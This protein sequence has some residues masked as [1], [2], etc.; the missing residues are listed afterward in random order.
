MAPT[1]IFAFNISADKEQNLV[2]QWHNLHPHHFHSHNCLHHH[3][4]NHHYSII[5]LYHPHLAI[6]RI[7]LLILKEA[8]ALVSLFRALPLPLASFAHFF[9]KPKCC[10]QIWLSRLFIIP[11][12][13]L[14]IQYCSA[15]LSVL[16]VA[17]FLVIYQ[18][19]LYICCGS[20][21]WGLWPRQ[22]HLTHMLLRS[23]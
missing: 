10:H 9:H 21:F 3:Q 1:A 4:L 13:M 16:S 23:R 14:Y 11:T 17:G 15:N 18:P 5:I 2:E 22:Q 12:C 6:L 19:H 8:R 7:F 20:G